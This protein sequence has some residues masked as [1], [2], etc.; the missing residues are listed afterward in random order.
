MVTVDAVYGYRFSVVV[1]A[2]LR[3]HD[4]D[5]T[6]LHFD[7]RLPPFPRCGS[8]LIAIYRSDVTRR[9]VRTS[10]CHFHYALF[11]VG[12]PTLRARFPHTPFT[13]IYVTDTDSV[14][15][16]SHGSI[17]DSVDLLFHP[18]FCSLLIRCDVARC[19][20]LRYRS[21]PRSYCRVVPHRFY[22]CSF[23]RLYVVRPLIRFLPI[24]RSIL[25]DFST[26]HVGDVRDDLHFP[27]LL[28]TTP[29]LR[30]LPRYCPTVRTLRCLIWILVVATVRHT[31][32]VAILH[33]RYVH[34]PFVYLTTYIS[35]HAPT[36]PCTRSRDALLYLL[37]R[38]IVH[39]PLERI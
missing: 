15:G 12:G 34:D 31:P 11:V 37:E 8:T 28:P 5:F 27:H 25:F 6:L 32:H 4:F 26:T 30:F 3:L 9:C 33:R 14:P 7:L 22:G 24:L 21:L 29:I 38:W 20:H 19:L 35:F 16:C 1:A 13:L 2:H 18:T 10:R 23:L 36:T 17:Y 39:L